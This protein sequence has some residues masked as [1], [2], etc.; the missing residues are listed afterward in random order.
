[1][2]T[3]MF[4]LKTFT[5]TRFDLRLVSVDP[6]S[7]VNLLLINNGKAKTSEDIEPCAVIFREGDLQEAKLS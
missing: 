1:M 3:E 2:C 6:K 7:N 4:D 5:V